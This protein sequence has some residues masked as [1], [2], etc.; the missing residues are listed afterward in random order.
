MPATVVT[1]TC[2]QQ[3]KCGSHA[4]PSGGALNHVK[5]SALTPVPRRVAEDG[6]CSCMAARR[7]VLN[8]RE[9]RG[10]SIGL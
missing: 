3:R 4:D 1:S 5:E 7:Q 2:R 6:H 8:G 9:Q 10:I